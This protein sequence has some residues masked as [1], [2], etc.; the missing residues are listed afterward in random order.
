MT[1]GIELETSK[2]ELSIALSLGITLLLISLVINILLY[3]IK[4]RILIK[5]I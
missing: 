5:Y 2:G 1:T 4:K 3:M